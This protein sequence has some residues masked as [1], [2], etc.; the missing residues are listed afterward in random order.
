MYP[1]DTEHV[2]SEQDDAPTPDQS[3][4]YLVT[5]LLLTRVEG[6]QRTVITH[7]KPY[8]EGNL[9]R[10]QNVNPILDTRL[11]TTEFPYG[12][13]IEISVNTAADSIFHNFDADGN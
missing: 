8:L 9:I 13:A 2:M 3:D 7:H 11:Y 6:Y 1:K 4:E 10:Q 5:K 12:E